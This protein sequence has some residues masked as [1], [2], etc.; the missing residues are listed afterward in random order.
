MSG[1][2]QPWTLLKPDPSKCQECGADHKPDFPHNRDSLY[3]QYNF[4]D[5]HGR[6][7][8][9]DDATEHVAPEMKEK[10]FAIMTELKFTITN[11]DNEKDTIDDDSPHPE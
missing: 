7:P 5:Q 4:Y 3:Y 8:T 6:W 1:R 10:F 9:W 2:L 11:N